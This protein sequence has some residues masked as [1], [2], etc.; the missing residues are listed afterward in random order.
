VDEFGFVEYDDAE[1][2]VGAALLYVETYLVFSY[3]LRLSFC[4]DAIS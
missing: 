1:E 3:K 2:A 4:R